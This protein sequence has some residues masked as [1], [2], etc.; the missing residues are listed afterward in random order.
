MVDK[1]EQKKKIHD[2]AAHIMITIDRL[3]VQQQNLLDAVGKENKDVL[4]ALEEGIKENSSTIKENIMI[5][6]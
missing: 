3:M 4:K 1:L 5:L 2:M 6:K